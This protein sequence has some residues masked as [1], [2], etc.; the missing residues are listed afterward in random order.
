MFS[1][2]RILQGLVALVVMGLVANFY[3][4]GGAGYGIPIH[5][6]VY[7][8]AAVASLAIPAFWAVTHL[9][10][11][12]VFGIAAGGFLDGVRLG[13]TLGLGMAF[14]KL[15]PTMLAVGLGILL[16]KGPMLYAVICLV[17]AVL[18]FALDKILQ[19]FWHST[20][21]GHDNG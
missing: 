14:G 17:A 4:N 15:W 6:Y 11:G 3:A 9:C 19:Y 16:G 13:L 1:I 12:I 20:S 18:L 8:G 10:G 5:P 7:Y 2:R 21:H